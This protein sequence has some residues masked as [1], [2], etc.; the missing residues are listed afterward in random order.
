LRRRTF[1]RTWSNDGASAL[2]PVRASASDRHRRRSGRCEFP[3]PSRQAPAGVSLILSGTAVYS[4]MHGVIETQTFL[5][6]AADAGM[7]EEERLEIVNWI[8]SDPVQGDLMPGTGGVRKV[9]FAGRG[10]G[11]SG[12]YCVVTYFAA[13]DVPVLLLAIINKGERADLSKA[14]RN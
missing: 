11:K 12:G 9:R 13:A 3:A 7:A 8:A 2:R 1:Q 10:K 6:D 5:K 14:E 4:A